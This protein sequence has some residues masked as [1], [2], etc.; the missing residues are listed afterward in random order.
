MSFTVK[1]VIDLLDLEQIEV[2]LFRGNSRDVGSGR[3][4]GGQV[5]GQALNAAIRT[6]DKD[7]LVHSL[8][9]YFILPGDIAKPI[10]F[11]VD[12]IR[13]GRSFATRR[14]VAIQ[15]GRAIFNMSAS[16]QIEEAGASHQIDMPNVPGPEDLRSGREI[17]FE[18]AEDMPEKVR[19]FYQREWP[20]EFRP[21]EDYNP[22]KP[23]VLPPVKN[24]WLRTTE[25]L[26]ENRVCHQCFLAYASDFNLLSTA[27][28]PHGISFITP[29]LQI[30]SL[31]HAMWFHR[32]FRVDE[33][34]LYSI[35]SPSAANARGFA[36][37]HLFTREGILV[38]SVTQE[39]LVR[40]R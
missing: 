11:E 36:Q 29:G 30:A 17:R 1:D 38:A 35:N 31:D 24:I 20:V 37:G 19:Q 14:V 4:F 18:Q 5:L 8:H 6:V 9:G 2:N 21:V 22:F 23:E 32:S 3:V 7:R 39:G 26:P 16:F 27:M 40:I 25:P 12:R 34:L 15:K 10:I 13:D 28:L 33:W